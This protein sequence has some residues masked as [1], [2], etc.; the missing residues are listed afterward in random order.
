MSELFLAKLLLGHKGKVSH[1]AQR[2]NVLGTNPCLLEPLPV[3]SGLSV[4]TL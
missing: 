3:E 1:I 4:T 2:T